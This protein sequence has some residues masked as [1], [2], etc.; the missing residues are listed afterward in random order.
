MDI[1]RKKYVKIKAEV[2]I[3]KFRDR[4]FSLRRKKKHKLSESKPQ[5]ELNSTEE[6]LRT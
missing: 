5:N 2:A 6:K 1:V 4:L 3:C